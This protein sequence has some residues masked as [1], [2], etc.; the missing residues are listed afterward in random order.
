MVRNILSTD[1]N[2]MYKQNVIKILICAHDAMFIR[3]QHFL[4]K[5]FI[6][7]KEKEKPH[8]LYLNRILHTKTKR[9]G[10]DKTLQICQV[11]STKFTYYRKKSREK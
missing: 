2:E 9:S 3:G 4:V 11:L 8:L 6:T 1:K 10:Q 5:K 7:R